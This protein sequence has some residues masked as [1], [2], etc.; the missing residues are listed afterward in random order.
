M[1]IFQKS[2]IQKHLSNLDEELVEKAYQK[3][4]ENYSPAKIEKI[5]RLKEEEYQDRF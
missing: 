5:K 2:V 1:A 3:F 4:R